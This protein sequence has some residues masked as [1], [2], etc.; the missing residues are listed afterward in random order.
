MIRSQFLNVRFG[1]WLLGTVTILG[2][3][4]I[5]IVVQKPVPRLHDEFSYVLMGETFARG[6]A[7]NPSPPLP[8][9]FD[10]FHVL[11]HP[12]YASKY[13]PVQ[14]IFLGLG[15]KLAG[16]PAVGLWLSSAL[17]CVALVWMLQAW[18]SPGWA[19]LGGFIVVIQYGIYSYW[20]QTYWGGMAAAL[21]GALFFGAVRRLWDRFSWQNS[22]WLTLGLV[23]L[24]NSRPLEGALAAL[25]ATIMLAYQIVKNRRWRESHFASRFV[26]PC[27][28]VG[29]LGGSAT[30]T[31]NRA[32]TGSALT[33]PYMLHEQQYQVSP[34]F[35][36]LSQRPA[37]TYSSIWLRY[38]YEF[39]ELHA[40]DGQRIPKYWFLAVG[41]KL[42][43]WWDF[44]FGLLLSVPLILPGLLKKGRIRVFQWILV[45]GYLALALIS[46][47]KIAWRVL[48]DVLTPFQFAVLWFVFDD[49]W[50]RL[51]IGTSAL[52]LIE[53]FFT[54]WS[55]AHYFCSGSVSHLVPGNAEFATNLALEFSDGTG[56]S[57]D[58]SRTQRHG[59]R[60][61]VSAQ[62][63]SKPSSSGVCDSCPVR[64]LPCAS[65]REPV[66]RRQY[67]RAWAR[68]R[69]AL[70][71]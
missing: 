29:A 25:P 56:S 6:H 55:F 60:K 54:K 38:Y 5:S 1:P 19:L 8:E 41:R 64:N 67:R 39:R 65:S 14:G 31:Y 66:E 35:I 63:H 9:F 12:V 40:Y 30:G 18:I 42:A 49:L 16:H 11:V 4:L 48:V 2:C 32:V 58:T 7:A 57:S 43:T 28:V 10:T 45:A 3:W 22:I 17:A 37:V 34:P 44:Y 36:F 27:L 69:Y 61:A 13:F 24:A 21:G 62:T 33:L 52:V 20:S 70:P 46:D 47:H 59:P 23:I 71:A 26:I 50:S 68:S 51:A 15:E 53:L